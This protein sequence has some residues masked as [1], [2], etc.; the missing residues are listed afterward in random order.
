MADLARAFE[1]LGF[2]EVKTILAS[3]NVRFATD[4]PN[5]AAL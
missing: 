1:D 5:N 2:S 4:Q 3:G